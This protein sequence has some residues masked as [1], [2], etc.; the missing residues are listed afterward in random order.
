MRAR[1]LR[2]A[3]RGL[4]VTGVASL[5][6]C[7]TFDDPSTVKDLRA[8]AV[9][10]EPSEVI[11]DVASA[12]DIADL[13]TAAIPPL[14]LTPLVV[15]PTGR[16]VSVTVSACANDPTAPASPSALSD[17]T[18]YPAGGI[19][20][21]VGSALCDAAPTEVP[22]ATAVD[23]ATSPS[24]E[25]QL[26]PAWVAAAFAHDVFAGA[27]GVVHG[28]FD[29]GMPVVFQLTATAGADTVR[30]IKRAIFWS[31]PVRA[32]QRAN[33]TPVIPGVRAYARRDE[34]TAEPLPG[35]A[36]ALEAGAPLDVMPDG[37][38]IEPVAAADPATTALAES[39]V[40]AT[41]DRTTG[42]VG[43]IDVKETLTYTFYASAGTFS[44]FQTSSEP[45]PGVVPRGRIHIE[46]KYHP[47]KDM[48]SQAAGGSALESV[49]VTIWIVVRDER[50]GSSWVERHLLVQ[51][52]TDR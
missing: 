33:A 12:A 20:N 30:T 39:Y 23:L 4:I 26:D 28:G 6:G 16:P 45:P 47:P 34:A 15:D 32:D 27:D 21:T 36:Q 51:P 3:A 40:T 44:P 18:G 49:P 31:Q 10:A 41:L 29:L 37:L 22:L 17:P 13:A 35:A 52:A 11:L 19:R 50:G 2:A 42:Q 43:P 46:S 7:G 48:S 9:T 5:A 14:V 38:W 1:R 25:V 24:I 8:L